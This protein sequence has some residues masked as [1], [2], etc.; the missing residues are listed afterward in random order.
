VGWSLR[1]DMW[2]QGFAL[3]AAEACIQ[4]AV[5]AL[6]WTQIVHTIDPANLGLATPRAK[7]W[8]QS[9]RTDDIAATAS[10]GGC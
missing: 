2:G 6:G 7:A 8:F 4:Y 3:E 5:D 10:R 9:D 1:R